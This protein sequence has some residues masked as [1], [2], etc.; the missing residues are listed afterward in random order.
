MLHEKMKFVSLVGSFLPLL[1][2]LACLLSYK[3]ISCAVCSS[4]KKERRRGEGER[5]G[6][7]DRRNCN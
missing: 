2:S 7:D 4:T 6:G 1:K 3:P 5:R